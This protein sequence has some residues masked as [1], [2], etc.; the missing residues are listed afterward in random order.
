MVVEGLACVLVNAEAVVFLIVVFELGFASPVGGAF[1]AEMVVGLCCEFAGSRRR[2]E[3][4]LRHDNRGGN[5]ETLLVIH[6]HITPLGDVLEVLL[7]LR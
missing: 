1:D 3:E 5:A 7:I 2:F 4:C 6:Y